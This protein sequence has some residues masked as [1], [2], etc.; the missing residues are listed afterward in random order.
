MRT[1]LTDNQ[2][3]YIYL[4]S[5]QTH[6]RMHAHIYVCVYIYSMHSSIRKSLGWELWILYSCE[7]HVCSFY[8]ESI[9]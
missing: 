9:V 3:L 7:Y 1:F 5:L 8:M 4:L 2:G 6:T